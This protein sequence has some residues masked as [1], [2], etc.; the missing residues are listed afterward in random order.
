MPEMA[1][2]EGEPPPPGLIENMK[3]KHRI[4]ELEA[5]LRRPHV[6]AARFRRRRYQL[7]R[8]LRRRALEVHVWRRP[9]G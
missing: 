7:R 6:E 9:E 3:D 8:H 4:M 1:S 5:L 2:G